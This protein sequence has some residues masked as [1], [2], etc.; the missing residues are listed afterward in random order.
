[1]LTNEEFN[2]FCPIDLIFANGTWFP[3][4]MERQ[5]TPYHPAITALIASAYTSSMDFLEN[6]QTCTSRRMC[7][8]WLFWFWSKFI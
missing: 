8:C 2:A 5:L 7:R 1:L 6:Q 4:A 3:N